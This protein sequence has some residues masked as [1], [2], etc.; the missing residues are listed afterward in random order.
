[1]ACLTL[2][3]DSCSIRWFVSAARAGGGLDEAFGLAVGLRATRP[4]ELLPD[5]Q[6]Q[7]CLG[8]SP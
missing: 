7:A 6:F 8:E 2:R 3:I 1:M 4:G 5:A